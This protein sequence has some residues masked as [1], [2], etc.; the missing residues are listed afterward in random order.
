MNKISGTLSGMVPISYLNMID[1][2]EYLLWDLND[3]Y[4]LYLGVS[5]FLQGDIRDLSFKKGRYF[6]N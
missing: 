1:I 4:E 2:P 5:D 3:N 6:V